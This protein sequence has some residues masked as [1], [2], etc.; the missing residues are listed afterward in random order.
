MK[1][2]VTGCG[3]Q[4]G[5]YLSELLL[6]KGYEVH[7]MVRRSSSANL[8]RISHILDRIK[9][10]DG[11]LADTS[12]LHNV[13]KEVE[14]DEIYNLAAMSHVGVSFHTP[15]YAANIDGL[16][17]LRL[18]EI[19]RKVV[20]ECKF[21]QA[22]TSEL[23]GKVKE[24]PQNENT[25]FNPQS[26]Y[27]IAKHFGH[28]TVLNYRE[29]YGIFACNGILMNHESF[30]RGENFVTK[31]IVKAAVQILKGEQKTLSLGNL[32]AQRDWGYAPEYVEGM[33]RMLQQSKPDD[34]VLATGETH[35]VREFLCEAFNYLGLDWTKYVV[36]DSGNFRPAEVDLLLGDPSKAK[37][38]LGWEAKTKFRGLVNLMVNAEFY[39]EKR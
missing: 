13:I 3:G 37:K 36:I 8:G 21:Y 5:S 39:G 17:V 12:S 25:P 11:D 32:D 6:E 34:Y 30:R 7:G 22:G 20:P 4:D 9:I 19:V 23:F 18:L 35:S 33:W 28:Q 16:G 15:E 14:P 31:K 26:P 38:N 27:A 10:Y 24:T 29:T 1:A 2:L